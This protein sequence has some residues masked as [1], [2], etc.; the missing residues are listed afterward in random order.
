M[1]I[2]VQNSTK[3]DFGL[4]AAEVIATH[5]RVQKA[6]SNPVIRPLPA[7]L[8]VAAGERLVVD[9]GDIDFVY[10]DGEMS[11]AHMMAVINSYWDEEIFQVDV[12]TSDSVVVADS[13]YAQTTHSAWGITGEAD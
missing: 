1:A 7:S 13:G 8:T 11:R 5:G 2:R 4:M 9:I 6:G 3:L 12:M 10:P